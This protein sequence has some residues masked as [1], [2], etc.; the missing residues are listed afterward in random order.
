MDTL[1][2]EFEN[3]E[4]REMAYHN[5]EKWYG[6]KVVERVD[7]LKISVHASKEIVVATGKIMEKHFGKKN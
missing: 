6:S 4:D 7:A 1:N 5:I 2:Y 3:I